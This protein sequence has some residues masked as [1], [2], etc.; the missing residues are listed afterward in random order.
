MMLY[1]K[2]NVVVD[3]ISVEMLIESQNLCGAQC[4]GRNYER[5]I[6]KVHW[7]VAISFSGHEFAD[8]YSVFEE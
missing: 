6:R 2:R 1:S 7:N 8:S 3:L 5:T 4:F